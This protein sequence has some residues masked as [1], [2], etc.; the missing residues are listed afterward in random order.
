[1]SRN[2]K[3]AEQVHREAAAAVAQVNQAK[4]K[5]ETIAAADA[6]LADWAREQGWSEPY[7]DGWLGQPVPAS[8]TRLHPRELDGEIE[9]LLEDIRS[10]PPHSAYDS[11]PGAAS[12]VTPSDA[13]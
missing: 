1:M 13:P 11:L 5:D 2:R 10:L 3:R 12:K 6:M 9:R 4:T 7:I 8:A